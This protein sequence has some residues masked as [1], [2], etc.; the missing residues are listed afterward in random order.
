M[1]TGMKNMKRWQQQLSVSFV[2]GF[3]DRDFLERVESDTCFLSGRIGSPDL[4]AGC[5]SCFDRGE[6]PVPL[7]G[8][9]WA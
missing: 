1:I 9:R 6:N 3:G 2:N 7:F 8:Y 5:G 4:M